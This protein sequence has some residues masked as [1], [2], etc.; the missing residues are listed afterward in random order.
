ML[1]LISHLLFSMVGK[2]SLQKPVPSS[3]KNGDSLLIRLMAWSCRRWWRRWR[4]E[5]NVD[6]FSLVAWNPHEKNCGSPLGWRNRR[7]PRTKYSRTVPCIGLWEGWW[8]RLAIVGFLCISHHDI[9]M[10]HIQKVTLLDPILFFGMQMNAECCLHLQDEGHCTEPHK[11]TN[12]ESC[13]SQT[14]SAFTIFHCW[15][16]LLSVFSWC[17]C[18]FGMWQAGNASGIYKYMGSSEQCGPFMSLVSENHRKSKWR[19]T[20]SKPNCPRWNRSSLVFWADLFFQ[21]LGKF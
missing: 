15:Y 1:Y 3:I 4:T 11:L 14:C 8:R 10:L 20:R 6:I 18:N 9:T 16:V 19:T 12:N 21:L 5:T 7:L 2:S 13:V 17:F